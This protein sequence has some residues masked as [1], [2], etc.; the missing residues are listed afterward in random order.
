MK[1]QEY[2]NR[3]N[4]R[5]K[6]ASMDRYGFLVR[7]ANEEYTA[8]FMETPGDWSVV[9]TAS[10]ETLRADGRQTWLLRSHSQEMLAVEHE[11]GIE[12][13]LNVGSSVTSTAVVELIS[14]AWRR[15]RNFR[16]H[17]IEN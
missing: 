1:A 2:E 13:L 5:V 16:A 8:F 10:V 14:W 3:G 6:F 15:W 11:T 7:D 4:W 12:F 9:D 17:E